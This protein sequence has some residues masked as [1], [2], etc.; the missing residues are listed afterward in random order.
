[1]TAEGVETKEQL[2]ILSSLNCDAIQGYHFSRPVPADMV[3]DL[4]RRYGD[5]GRTT[6]CSGITLKP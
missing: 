4:L 2:E 3:E 5:G 1:V 6:A